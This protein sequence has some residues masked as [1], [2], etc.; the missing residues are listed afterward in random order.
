MN[1]RYIKLIISVGILA[2]VLGVYLYSIAPT[3]SFWDC[4]EL[5]ACSY[6][7]GIPHPPGTPLF[8]LIGRIF[9]LI[10]LA[11]EVAFRINFL[12][13]LFGAISCVLIYLLVLKLISIAKKDQAFI[14]RYPY[15][16]HIAGVAAAF[17]LAFAYSFWD[18][19]VETEVYTP[20]VVA[21]LIVL[22][23]ALIWREK[24]EA[25]VGDNRIVLFAIYLLFLSAG[26]HFTP[27][28]ILFPLLVYA[29]LIDRDAILKLHLVELLVLFLII[30]A[31][32]GLD[33]VDYFVLFLASP[34]VAIIQ[35][36][37]SKF[38]LFI[39]LI[40]VFASY[41][42]YLY[43]KGKLD[44]QYVFWGL[45]FIMLAGTVQFYLLVRSRLEPPI[46][47]VD[48]QRWADFVSVLKREQYDPMKL[49]PRKTQFLTEADYRNYPNSYPAFNVFVA[50]FEQ[51]KFYLRYF[52]WQW[53][54]ERYFDIF[55]GI[56]WPAIFGIIPVIL[57]GYG[58]VEHYKKDRKSWWLIFLCFL[59][60][61]VGLVTYLN[62]KYSPSDPRPHL[63][64]RE[65]RERDYF[66]AF[67]YVFYTIFI[68]L[69]T[70]AFLKWL[71][72][73]FRLNQIG[74]LA[75]CGLSIILM[76]LPIA[77][78]YS[79]VSRRGNW[80]PAEYGYNMLV[81]CEG[82]KAI[83]F[84]NGDNDTFPLW[85]VQF[86]PNR[87]AGYDPNFGKNIAVAN[88]SLLNT[89]WFIKQLKK[90]GAPISFS[91]EEID[92]LPQ[93][94]IGAGRRTFLLKDIMIRDILATNSGI[95]L[96]WP[97]DYVSPASD[98][99][100]KVMD[101]YKEGVMPVYFATT[102]DRAEN[103]K[104]VEPYLRLEGLVNRVTNVKSLG[105][106]NVART[107]ELFDKYKMESMMDPKVIKDDNTRGLFLN[108]IASFAALAQ[109]YQKMGR[110]D[111]AI[112]TLE[113]TLGFDIDPD[114][115]APIYYNLSV[116]AMLNQ[117]Y[118]LAHAY[119]DSIER[120][121]IKD[122]PELLIR[123]GW[124]YQSQNDFKSAEDA[125]LKARQIAPN[126]AEP[127]QSLVSLYTEYL[128]DTTKAIRTLQEWLRINPRD[129]NARKML[130][131]LQKKEEKKEE[132]PK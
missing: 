123:R 6:V 44:T 25:G 79:S 50:Y 52:L 116:F 36:L 15:V 120:M 97:E 84:T 90:W 95:K 61:S 41:L 64:F 45:V 103:L 78:N 21:A 111:L 87:P 113:R 3:A 114:K 108:Y 26:I 51:L 118:K 38:I 8:V 124:I 121:G 130:E 88:L 49:F 131:D 101:N 16:P 34:P 65:V 23:L 42:Y 43:S 59:V 53:G 76:F 99:M 30:V 13:A 4:G 54:G 128:H 119:L 58:I 62:L 77:F 35:I 17:A 110:M 46:N 56:R 98:F 100:A 122:D 92:R 106:V 32:A 104:D 86:V 10:P 75:F 115:K 18:N 24:V 40:G 71:F 29:F 85:F 105:Q 5:I 47:E 2:V 55:L 126:Q 31:I 20:C 80:I 12:T 96:K 83:I 1:R 48:P 7:L 63:K 27:L 72:T 89:N 117:D 70:F 57:G 94:L 19:S 73:N 109:E 69:G 67:S 37:Y 82:E 112:K 127:V 107:Q 39:L 74:R 14:E 66:F 91:L 22:Y 81:S 132:K 68:G 125:Y 102:V 9:S 93:G 11:R 60:A 129:N 33:L 28:M